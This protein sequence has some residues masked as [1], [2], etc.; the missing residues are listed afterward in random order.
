[1]EYVPCPDATPAAEEP[2]PK[3]SLQYGDAVFFRDIMKDVY[4][5]LLKV[6]DASTVMKIMVI[7][8]FHVMNP[9]RTTRRIRTFYTQSYL[10]IYYPGAALSK[11]TITALYEYLGEQVGLRLKFNQMRVTKIEKEHHIVLDSTLRQDTSTVNSLSEFS[12]KSRV[13]GCKDISVMYAFDSDTMEPVCGLVYPGNTADSIAYRDFIVQNNITRG[14]L[15]ADKGFSFKRVRELVRSKCDLSFIT[16]LKSNDSRITS[17]KMTEYDGILKNYPIYYKKVKLSTGNYL[18][19]FN[20]PDIAADVMSKYTD[21]TKKDG[22]Y[23]YEKYKAKLNEAGLIVFESDL[24]LEPEKIYLI[25]KERWLLE[26]CFR[27][28]KN[29]LDFDTTRVQSDFAVIGDEFIR[30]VSTIAICRMTRRGIDAGVLDDMTFGDM[31]DDLST[32]W[33]YIDAPDPV[34]GDG[35]WAHPMTMEQNVVLAR[36]DIAKADA[37]TAE[38]IRKSDNRSLKA[39]GKKFKNNPD[40]ATDALASEQSEQV[41]EE[42]KQEKRKRGR[43]AKPKTETKEKRKRGRPAKPKTETKEKR[44]PGRPRKTETEVKEKRKPGRPRTKKDT[45][46]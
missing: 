4:V 12:R 11:N 43:P 45:N 35:W 31:M 30:F 41:A 28:Y 34:I 5:D 14:I 6:F 7:A 46:E 26:M 42:P 22:T 20:D 19:S 15:V 2:L 40:A 16:P 37:E 17:N 44:K 13:R 36:L 39:K 10:H 38:E 32:A 29:D 33:R 9:Y 24:D 25:Y 3:L 1:M 8:A 23:S 18:Y 21:K 27:M